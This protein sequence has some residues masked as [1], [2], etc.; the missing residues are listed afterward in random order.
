MEIFKKQNNV[1]NKKIVA[2]GESFQNK[3]SV[4]DTEICITD[5]FKA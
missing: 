2:T 1:L 5:I 4:C 3:N